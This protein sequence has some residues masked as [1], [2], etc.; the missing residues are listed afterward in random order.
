[1][2]RHRKAGLNS[3]VALDEPGYGVV[4]GYRDDVAWGRYL[5][6]RTDALGRSPRGPAFWVDSPSFEITGRTSRP[7]GRIHRKNLKFGGP[8][9]QRGCSCECCP[10]QPGWADE[11][12][13]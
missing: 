8:P 6:V 10:H 12:D 5:V 13:D 7:P 2:S 9:E 4:I 3:V 1:V 11:S